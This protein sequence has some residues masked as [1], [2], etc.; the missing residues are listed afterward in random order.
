M[1]PILEVK[2]KPI[3]IDNLLKNEIL[4]IRLREWRH[5]RLDLQTY[6]Y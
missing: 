6:K 3:S 4:S 5:S 2:I 1:I